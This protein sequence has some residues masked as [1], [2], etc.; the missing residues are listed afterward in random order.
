VL[1][2]SLHRSGQATEARKTLAAAILEHDLRAMKVSPRAEGPAPV[3]R[4]DPSAPLVGL[5]LLPPKKE[6]QPITVVIPQR[7]EEVRDRR[8]AEFASVREP[9]KADEFDA[10]GHQSLNC[11]NGPAMA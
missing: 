5:R 8:E 1:A 11:D 4:R 2:L 10:P 3:S 7:L 6:R 9:R